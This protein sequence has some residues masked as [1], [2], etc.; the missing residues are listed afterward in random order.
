M[1][2]KVSLMYNV[3]KSVLCGDLVEIMP[4]CLCVRPVGRVFVEY[5]GLHPW[6]IEARGM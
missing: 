2:L 4:K 3:M 5:S 1:A 6:F